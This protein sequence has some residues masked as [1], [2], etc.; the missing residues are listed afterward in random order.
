[1]NH[2]TVAANL[3]PEVTHIISDENAIA[4]IERREHCRGAD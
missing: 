4:I 1:M 2:A 3:N